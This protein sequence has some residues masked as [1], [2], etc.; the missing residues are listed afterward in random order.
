[1]VGKLRLSEWTGRD[2]ERRSKLQ[3]ST[4]TKPE[5]SPGTPGVA[6]ACSSSAS[7]SRPGSPTVPS[8]RD[9][10]EPADRPALGKYR[11][12]G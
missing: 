6:D 7:R 9:G 2:G 10:D 1:M 11:K 5:V 8:L 3:V 12:A 4:P